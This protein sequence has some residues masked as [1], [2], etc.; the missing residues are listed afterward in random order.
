MATIRELISGSLRILGVV[1]AG[2]APGAPDMEVARSALVSLLDSWAADRLLVFAVKPHYFQVAG[3]TAEYTIGPGANF[4]TERPVRIEF[5]SFI[6]DAALVGDVY[7]PNKQHLFLKVEALNVQEFSALS[8][9]H[10]ESPYPLAFHS[11]QNSP[12]STVTLY[13]KPTR[14]GV[15]VLY[16]W[17]PFDLDVD[18]DTELGFPPGYERALRFGL[19]VELAPEFGKILAPEVMMIAASAI[20]KIRRANSRPQTLDSTIGGGGF[21]YITGGFT[22][23]P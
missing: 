5:A 14:S 4:N 2:Q 7:V 21:H 9:A 13:P 1:Q 6:P 20:G 18:L 15:L 8:M 10:L 22:R 3:G 23:F 11:D 16:I 17:A 12:V 19:A